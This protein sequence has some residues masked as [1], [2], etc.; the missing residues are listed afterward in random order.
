MSAGEDEDDSDPRTAGSSFVTI[1]GAC[2][3]PF[4]HEHIL[5]L[6]FGGGHQLQI[7]MLQ[8]R[9]LETVSV[10][11]IICLKLMQNKTFSVQNTKLVLIGKVTTF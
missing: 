11:Q 2:K 7:I 6:T 8:T 3:L 10:L 5:H 1:H 9:N 4:N